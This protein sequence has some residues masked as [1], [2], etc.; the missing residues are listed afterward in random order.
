MFVR[1]SDGAGPRLV[2]ELETQKENFDLFSM[3]SWM[4]LM[5][6]GNSKGVIR[7]WD[8]ERGACVTCIEAHKDSDAV[9]ALAGCAVAGERVGM[10]RGGGLGGRHAAECARA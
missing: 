3:A 7:V 9:N 8:V 4:G 5:V 10:R 2:K 1:D 6:S